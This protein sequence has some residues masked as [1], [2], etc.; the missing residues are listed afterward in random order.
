MERKKNAK[1]KE[2]KTK[3]ERREHGVRKKLNQN[4]GEEKRSTKEV[5]CGRFILQE[6]LSHI[7][8]SQIISDNII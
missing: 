8:S 4:Q 7:K 5:D 3:R 1:C 2:E 6:K